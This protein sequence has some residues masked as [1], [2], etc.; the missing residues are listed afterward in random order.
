MLSDLKI[1]ITGAS[2]STGQSLRSL[3]AG[4]AVAAERVRLLERAAEEAIIS[5]YA[6][7]PTIIGTIDPEALV[8]RD[9]VFLCGD[10]EESARCLLWE[11]KKGSVFIDLSGATAA[12]GDVP[13]VNAAVN[14]Q[15]LAEH[16]RTLA[17]PHA[18]S[19]AI[20][21]ALAPLVGAFPVES[22]SA[23]VLRPASDFGEPGIE[24]LHRQTVALLNFTG[25]PKSVYGRQ[26]GF[27]LIPQSALGT[28]LD[29]LDLEARLA[30]EVD[31]IF[32]WRPPRMAL[33]AL[34]APVFHGTA[35]LIHLRVGENPSLAT[36]RKVLA[37]SGHLSV[38]SPS[39]APL[40]PVEVVGQ[41]EKLCATIATDD[42]APGGFWIWLV[43]ADFAAQSAGNAVEIAARLHSG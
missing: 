16:P 4:K 29:G 40:S 15:R 7:Q 38:S 19:C 34:V 11:R 9:L 28:S 27:N 21:S 42:A 5:E 14:P 22:V 17:A 36:A 26:L 37:G 18:I 20:T 33:R 35:V 10:V 31:R 1:A 2:G 3:L 32:D 39:G 25:L 8:D 6:G 13:V 30:R 23:V 41:Q 24:E 43:G 12:K